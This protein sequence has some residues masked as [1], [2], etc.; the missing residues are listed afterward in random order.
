MAQSYNISTLVP[1]EPALFT[2][3][4]G[5]VDRSKPIRVKNLENGFHLIENGHHRV[6]TA[7][8]QGRDSIEGEEDPITGDREAQSLYEWASS[9]NYVGLGIQQL[10]LVSSNQHYDE[11]LAQQ[12]REMGLR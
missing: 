2:N 3:K 6:R 9:K 1:K 8:D 4:V 12:L 5:Q 11:H 10:P 7:I